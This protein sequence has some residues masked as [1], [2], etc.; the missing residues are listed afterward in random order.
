MNS[1]VF[2]KVASVLW[3]LWGLVHT[4]AGVMTISNDTA[5]AVQAIADGAE[6]SLLAIAY[7]DAVGAI[8]NQHGWNLLWGGVVTIVGAIYIWRSN[9]TAIYVTAIIGGLLDLG[10]FMFL[11]LGGYVN[12]VPGTV[13]TL[14]SSLAIILSITAHR[15]LMKKSS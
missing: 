9:V 3:I 11:D 5:A 15:V 8:I 10:Y 1:S 13:M 6:P 4:L 2:L 12:F 7:P 14:V